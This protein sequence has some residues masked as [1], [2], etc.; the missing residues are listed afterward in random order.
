MSCLLAILSPSLT[1]SI[2][3]LKPVQCNYVL[4]PLTYG[5]KQVTITNPCRFDS[6]C[7]PNT[8]I[9]IQFQS[10]NLLYK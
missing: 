7:P 10:A 3:D 9:H 1:F 8:K 4:D 5:I 6:S 2:Q